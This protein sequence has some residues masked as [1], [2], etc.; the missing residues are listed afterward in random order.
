MK[1][2]ALTFDDG[3][4]PPFTEQILA[5]LRKKQIPAAFFV[6]GAN[7]KRH[8][9]VLKLIK[10]DGH[11]I[12]NHSYFH[13]PLTTRLGLS[14]NEI[15]KTQLIIEELTSQTQRFFRPPWG[16][17]PFWLK[18]RL[19]KQGFA[20]VLYDVIGFDW[21]K[22][23][24]PYDIANNVIR[25]AHDGGIILLHDGKDISQGADRSKTVFA[26]PIIIDSLSR[27]GFTFVSILE[28]SG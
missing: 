28:V 13:H 10:Q 6:C 2:I 3:P 21:K 14:Y 23:I 9:K 20:I 1:K 22:N 12:G 7:V 5:I 27:A 17:A 11:I 25:S 26:L 8:P 4:N 19:R 15:M 18:K 24:S 16:E